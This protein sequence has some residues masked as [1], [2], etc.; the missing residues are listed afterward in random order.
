M[1]EGIPYRC[2][3]ESLNAVGVEIS[4]SRDFGINRIG[5]RQAE[6]EQKGEER[7]SLIVGL[8]LGCLRLPFM[9]ELERTPAVNWMQRP[10]SQRV[11]ALLARVNSDLRG[12]STYVALFVES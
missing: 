10:T 5:Y 9:V 12:F 6:R 8:G 2:I 1:K 4:I 11:T 3:T 7:S